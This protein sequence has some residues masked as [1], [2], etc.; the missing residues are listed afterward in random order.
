MIDI[1][2][3]K[4]GY[5]KL[6]FPSFHWLRFSPELYYWRRDHDEGSIQLYGYGQQRLLSRVS[7]ALCLFS[8]ERFF[9]GGS[10]RAEAHGGRP[11]RA[12]QRQ[13]HFRTHARPGG[14]VHTGQQRVPLQGVGLAHQTE[15]CVFA[16]VARCGRGARRPTKRPCVPG[17]GRVAPLL[18][19]PSA[20]TLPDQS[21]TERPRSIGSMEKVVTLEDSMRRLERGVQSGTLS[22]HFEVF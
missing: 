5:L 20:L 10:M 14:H 18:Q 19:L 16:F 2:S 3:H 8:Q 15:R 4:P 21:A 1:D 13:R 11:G 7:S 6:W 22:F 9:A 12:H 17:P